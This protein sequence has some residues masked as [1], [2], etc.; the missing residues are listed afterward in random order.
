MSVINLQR[1]E[2]TACRSMQSIFYFVENDDPDW[3]FFGST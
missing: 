1:N 3:L 2:T